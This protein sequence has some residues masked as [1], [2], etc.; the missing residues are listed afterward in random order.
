MQTRL[1]PVP[2]FGH[3]RLIY[4]LPHVHFFEDPGQFHFHKIEEHLGGDGLEP[5]AFH[6][7]LDER[8]EADA[9][10][11]A[12]AFL[13]KE[14]TLVIRDVERARIRLHGIRPFQAGLRRV[15]A[16]GIHGIQ[17]LPFVEDRVQ[18]VE[19]RPIQH[20]G[21]ARLGVR[22]PAL[23]QPE[24]LPGG[25]GHQVPGPG[26]RE[27]VRDQIRL[28][29]RAQDRGGSQKR[30]ARVFH[31]SVRERRREHQQVVA[32]PQ[33]RP[34]Q[35]LGFHNFG[36]VLRELPGR[37]LDHLR[38]GVNP[39]ARTKF[40][41]LQIPRRQ[42]EQIGRDGLGHAENE[43]PA[44]FLTFNLF[45]G[46]DGGQPFGHFHLRR[47]REAHRRR[48]LAR[49]DTARVDV[50]ALAVK[51]GM[52]PAQR[53]RGVEP[54]QGNRIR[55]GAEHQCKTR[56]AVQAFQLQARTQGFVVRVEFPLQVASID[57]R[58]LHFD[59]VRIQKQR[60]AARRIQL[61]GGFHGERVLGKIRLDVKVNV[62]DPPLRE[63]GVRSGI[64]NGHG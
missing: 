11:R 53:L 6:I 37:G 34:Q 13:Q 57:V 4:P 59:L 30:Q 58:L 61:I 49:K 15:H 42:S 3:A 41:E 5:E 10:H 50:L 48:I 20:L 23:V 29:A 27:F 12:F 46:H 32:S 22:C 40:A 47:K 9:S 14:T 55:R 51:E 36:F 19:I 54:L 17:Q 21:D 45:R 33:I 24:I 39:R 63:V 1:V 25:V 60:T 8:I 56:L 18:V 26:V 52:F 31:P 16:E 64:V 44:S 28:S 38:L 7:L 35:L 2:A 43:T 62:P